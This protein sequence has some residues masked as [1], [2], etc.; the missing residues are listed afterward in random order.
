V[1]LETKY[2]FVL[3][4]FCV[5]LMIVG[6]FAAKVLSTSPPRVMRVVFPVIAGLTLAAFA[7]L[8]YIARA[9]VKG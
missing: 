2:V 7:T 8:T 6:T 9:H 3:A 5:V 1:S 4:G